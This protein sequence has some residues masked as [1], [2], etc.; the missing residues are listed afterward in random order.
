MTP[1]SHVAIIAKVRND[2]SV[3]PFVERTFDLMLGAMDPQDKQLKEAKRILH[4]I[5]YET[6]GVRF[7]P[8]PGN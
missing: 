3:G 5:G 6:R 8:V 1:M 4:Q 7:E 2:W